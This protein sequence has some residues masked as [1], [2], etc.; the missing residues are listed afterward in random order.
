M[1]KKKQKIEIKNLSEHF[2]KNNPV[3]KFAHQVNKAG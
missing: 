1:S 3:A 2:T